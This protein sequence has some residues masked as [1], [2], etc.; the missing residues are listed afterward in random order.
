MKITDI[1]THTMRV[2]FIR[3]FRISL[4]VMTHAVSCLVEVE[5]D[6]GI[7]GFGEGSPGPLITGENLEGTVESIRVLGQRLIGMDPRDMEAVY[8][9]MNRTIAYGGAAKAAIDIACHDILG[10][11]S[12]LPLYKVLGGLDSRIETDMTVGIDTPQVM[13]ALAKE[14]VK[15]GFG[16]IKTK[17]GTDIETDLARVKAIREAVGDDVKIRLDAN[18]GWH[19]KEAVALLERLDEYEIELV[20]QPVPGYDF[21]GLK[22]VTDHSRVPVMADESCWDSRD[23]LKLVSHRAVDFINIKLMKC[24]GL[25]EA[26]KIVDIAQAAGVECMLGC[27][28]EESGIAING[29]AALGAALKNITRADLDAGFSLTQLP[30]EGGFTQ[31]DTKWLI[32]SEQP[33]LGLGC[34]RKE[35]LQ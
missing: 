33:G 22:Y 9:V 3:P 12:G 5:T 32:L 23:A 18:Q 10:K 17:V 4:G 15:A 24:G 11:S 6:E 21:E 27:M 34:L 31:K 29:A 1:K 30:F 35:M 19:A 8:T 25:Y 26:K 14:H 2:P 13:A 16:V 20:E 28:A 7:T